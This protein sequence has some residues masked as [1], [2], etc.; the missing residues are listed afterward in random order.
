MIDATDT[1]VW[2]QRKKKQTDPLKS[3]AF[4][5]Y[6]QRD[7]ERGGGERFARS[8]MK[9]CSSEKKKRRGGIEWGIIEADRRA[10]PNDWS[11]IGGLNYWKYLLE[12]HVCVCACMCVCTCDTCIRLHFIFSTSRVKKQFENFTN[13][14]RRYWNFIEKNNGCSIRISLQCNWRTVIDVE[15]EFDRGF[16]LKTNWDCVVWKFDL[17]SK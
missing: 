13:E 7:R 16:M 14:I 8:T 4:I 2:K 17:N 15:R 1:D 3:T 12:R 5:L 10:C 9:G 11:I 6:T